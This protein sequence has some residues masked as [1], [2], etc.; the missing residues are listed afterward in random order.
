LLKVLGYLVQDS[1]F[2]NDP[3]F[4]GNG[5]NEIL[6]PGSDADVDLDAIDIERQE[7]GGVQVGSEPSS[8]SCTNSL[9]GTAGDSMVGW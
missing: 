5:P 4:V 8:K 7:V 3:T 2:P 9:I 1:L 6:G